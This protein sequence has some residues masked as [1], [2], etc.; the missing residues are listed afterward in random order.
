MKKLIMG[1]I[2]ATVLITMLSLPVTAER[3][4][5]SY[6]QNDSGN[7]KVFIDLGNNA[8]GY[9]MLT[10]FDKDNYDATTFGEL[11]DEE[12]TSLIQYSKV[13]QLN[14]GSAEFEVSIHGETGLYPYMISVQH[15]SEVINE[16]TFAYIA[17]ESDVL[18][19][20]NNKSSAELESYL[21]TNAAL[22]FKNTGIYTNSTKTEICASMA[23]K[24]YESLDL[25]FNTAYK[26]SLENELNT[27]SDI[28]KIKILTL[29]DEVLAY[30]KP[31]Y[32]IFLSSNDTF[33][34]D[35][36]SLIKGEYTPVKLYE[37]VDLIALKNTGN[38]TEI[39]PILTRM[40]Q[41]TGID[42]SKYFNLTDTFAVDTK[43]I[44]VDCK[45]GTELQGVV[46]KAI[47]D[48]VNPGSGS[49]S[50]SGMSGGGGVSGGINFSKSED[51]IY[52]P[53]SIV[54]AEEKTPAF[55]DL[56]GYDWAEPAIKVLATKG[57][58]NGK[59]E[60]QFAPSD[61][62]SREELVK[63]L[64]CIFDIYDSG[65]KSRFADL[66]G[67]WSDSYVA[68][69]EKYGLVKGISYDNFGKELTVTREDMAVLCYRFMN[70]FGVKLDT[71]E[72][73]DFADAKQISDYAV[74]AVKL[75][76]GA[77]VIKGKP[78][79]KFAPKDGCNRAEA[80]KVV[81]YIYTARNK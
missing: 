5:I 2:F 54:K 23:D 57:I 32:S 16:N 9:V 69:A 45:N 75:M 74:E 26:V 31:E 17:A 24:N 19:N 20:I 27:A 81:Y 28:D 3:N 14:N 10:V 1:L 72:T 61:L 70:A 36:V 50:S 76:K 79:G 30:D 34:S 62:I 41:S 15:N 58:L 49:G 71:V 55:S 48:T 59:T 46:A 13:E 12:K 25:A 18:S 53:N 47:S 63:M 42:L 73:E 56:N 52:A 68:S 67:H 38:Y 21:N 6:Y 77:N 64:V 51:I 66:D 44:G 65:A 7:L 29:Y 11:S 39:K 78:D 43:L 35:V 80:A 37:A 40:I 8:Y 22:V 33:K 4:H 60:G